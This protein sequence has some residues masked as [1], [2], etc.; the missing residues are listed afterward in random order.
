MSYRNFYHHVDGKLSE[1]IFDASQHNEQYYERLIKYLRSQLIEN[2]QFTTCFGQV[3]TIY[4]DY[5]AS[6]QSLEFIEQFILRECLPFYA[7][8]HTRLNRNAL[9]TTM[10]RDESRQIIRSS[11]N[12]DDGDAVIFIGSGSTAAVHL[13]IHCLNLQTKPII[14]SS[15]FEHHSNLLPWKEVC[16]E[17]IIINE[18]IDSGLIDIDQLKGELIKLRKSSSSRQIIGTFNGASNINGIEQPIDLITRIMHENDSL[19]FWDYSASAPY[20]SLNMNPSVDGQMKYLTRKDAMY[21][22]MH[23]FLGGP[24]TPGILIVKKKLLNNPIPFNCGGGSVFFVRKDSEIYLKNE[25][26]REEG[27]TAAIMESIRAG[28][29]ML[30]NK[31]L[32]STDEI[33]R[34]D[35][36]L[37][38]NIVQTFQKKSNSLKLLGKFKRKLPIFSFLINVQLQNR[39]NSSNRI[40]NQY[41]HYNFV[42]SLLNDLFGICSRGGCSCAGPYAQ[43]LLGMSNDLVKKFEKLLL[44]GTDV[45]DHQNKGKNEFPSYEIYRPGFTRISLS[46]ITTTEELCYVMEVLKFIGKFGSFFLPL[47]RY[48][49]QTGEYVHREW[50]LDN[51]R[52]YLNNLHF[53]NNKIQMK[54]ENISEKKIDMSFHQNLI[55]SINLLQMIIK[56]PKKSK[57]ENDIKITTNIDDDDGMMNYQWFLLQNQVTS[58]IHL[59]NKSERD[60]YVSILN[61]I[62]KSLDLTEINQKTNEFYDKLEIF[63]KINDDSLLNNSCFNVKKYDELISNSNTN[64]IHEI[65]NDSTSNLQNKNCEIEM[66][67]ERK[68]LWYTPPKSIRL[69]FLRAIKDFDMIRNNDRVLVCLSGGKDSLTLLQSMR[70]LQFYLEAQNIQF[71]LGALTIDPQS[72][73]Y[74]PSPLKLYLKELNVPYLY[75]EQNIIQ[76]AK[77]LG[78]ECRSICSFCS[79]MKRGRMYT[80]ARREGWNVLALGQHLDD[81][82]ESFIMS[83]FHNGL[84]RT[85]KASYTVKE[86]DLRIIRPLVYCR[87]QDLKHFALSS[88]LPIISENCPGCFSA[89]KERNRIKGIL[90]QQESLFPNLYN[91]LLRAMEPIMNINSCDINVPDILHQYIEEHLGKKEIDND[92]VDS[93]TS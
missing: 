36:Y 80:A 31:Q 93:T 35:Q 53:D 60:H 26:I 70:F 55:N 84:L 1:I 64:D 48:D 87:E 51:N 72:A 18:D 24:Q 32:L 71:E 28:L 22:S 21:F 2:G 27:G 58:A 38:D 15:L 5:A 34:R 83:I 69:P 68:S 56:Y 23:K 89:P 67:M 6:G 54:N 61:G 7:N 9:I 75:E 59:M 19:V 43:H 63:L 73:D 86:K 49:V 40:F 13:L 45:N 92:K 78:D 57:F 62:K 14:I 50:K 29:V 46:Y 20:V 42:T 91:S 41:L 17:M 47:Y 3:K 33:E 30:V 52:I 4:C 65:V 8:T 39:I 11:T 77:D 90:A 12:A 37:I 16:E 74:D 66:K 44:I 10:L 79:R 82:A 85:I 81:L 88:N 25:E 76:Q